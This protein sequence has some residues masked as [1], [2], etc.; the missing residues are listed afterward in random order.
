MEDLILN[1][2]HEKKRLE[3]FLNLS[4]IDFSGFENQKH[5]LQKESIKVSR[6][7]G[8]LENSKR[9]YLTKED[10]DSIKKLL[11]DSCKKMGYE[12]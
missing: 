8:L 11:H 2:E 3:D 6:S 7:K 5:Y 4:L 1:Y 12:L 9:N 10:Q